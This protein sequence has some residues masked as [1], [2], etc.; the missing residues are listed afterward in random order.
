MR[1]RSMLVRAIVFVLFV[2][3]S[4]ALAHDF[5]LLPAAPNAA[6]GSTLPV[7]AT[8]SAEFPA[9]GTPVPADRLREARAFGP[10]GPLRFGYASSG[11]SPAVLQ[12]GPVTPGMLVAA[13]ALV[14]RE[15]EY[16]PDR[17]PLIMQEY[18][19][20]AEA[21][22]A[23]AA[24]GAGGTLR[25]SSQRFAKSLICVSPCTDMAVATRPVGHDL[26]WVAT[27]TAN[28]FQLLSGGR[29]LANYPVA[30]VIGGERRRMRTDARGS[31]SAPSGAPG[32]TMLFAAVMEQP[33]ATGGRFTM[34]L[35]SLTFVGR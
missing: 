27:A 18:E 17:V 29:P 11:P 13:V 6:P 22:R 8:V 5:V 24:L 33:A 1:A 2:A 30:V 20:G 31:V 7:H 19:V 32:P 35:A 14:P 3:A 23:V 21:Q 4:P 28:G 10:S 25:A 26:E 15:V 9:L 16:G 34:K 12:L